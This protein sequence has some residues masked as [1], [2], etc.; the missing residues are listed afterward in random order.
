VVYGEAPHVNWSQFLAY[1]ASIL[2]TDESD[3][4]GGHGQWLKARKRDRNGQIILNRTETMNSFQKGEIAYKA[5]PLG[6]YVNTGSCDKT[7]INVLSV[8]C[9]STDCKN[10]IASK[11]KIEKIIFIKA[12][13]IKKLKAA[14]PASAEIRIEEAEL[15]ALQA[16]LAR[17]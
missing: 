5:T 16:G 14:D 15:N 2:L 1:A 12:N 17:A 11:K 4:F 6:G 10:L 13:T 7:P 8:E 3:I 9:I